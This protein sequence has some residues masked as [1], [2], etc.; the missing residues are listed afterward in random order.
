MKYLEESRPALIRIRKAIRCTRQTLLPNRL[1]L[2]RVG[3]RTQGTQDSNG[4]T[5]DSTGEFGPEDDG[6][7]NI[8]DG[9]DEEFPFN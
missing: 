2:Q 9:I 4:N 1:G 5:N 3:Q 6:F 8:P 7:M